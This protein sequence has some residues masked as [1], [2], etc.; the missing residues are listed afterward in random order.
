MLDPGKRQEEYYQT[1]INNSKDILETLLVCDLPAA[2]PLQLFGTFAFASGKW[3]R[4]KESVSIILESH[5][6]RQAQPFL[7]PAPDRKCF[8]AP[9]FAAQV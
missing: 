7:F 4:E 9:Q 5:T 3:L 8:F 6:R 2:R 1:D